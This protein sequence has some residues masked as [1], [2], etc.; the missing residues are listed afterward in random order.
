MILLAIPFALALV[1]WLAWDWLPAL[2][3]IGE[4]ALV[5]AVLACVAEAC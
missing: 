5:V 2:R 1:L 3:L 4:L